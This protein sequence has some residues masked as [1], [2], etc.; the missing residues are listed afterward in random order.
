MNWDTEKGSVSLAGLKAMRNTNTRTNTLRRGH[1][2]VPFADM[3]N[4][5]L[6]FVNYSTPL[7]TL[8]VEIN[9]NTNAMIMY[10]RKSV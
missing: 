5:V 2:G 4:V 9:L 1:V 3:E 8:E 6:D 10:T 7:N